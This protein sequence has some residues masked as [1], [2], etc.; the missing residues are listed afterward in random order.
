MC[1]ILDI[2]DYLSRAYE[3]DKN[4]KIEEELLQYYLYLCQRESLAQH[5]RV[6]FD[7]P[8]EAWPDGPVSPLVRSH[9]LEKLG[10]IDLDNPH[11]SPRAKYIINCILDQYGDKD[12][13]YL[14]Q[15]CH[16]EY[17]WQNSRS[18]LKSDDAEGR[19]INID[20][21]RKDAQHVRIFDSNWGMY[22][23]EFDDYKGGQE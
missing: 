15:L 21:M 22:R 18:R 11:L 1:S 17:S 19:V 7:E 12:C 3:F 16:K 4:K 20:D 2:A 5:G 23:D 8:I 9:F 13:Y 6:L 10:R 14:K